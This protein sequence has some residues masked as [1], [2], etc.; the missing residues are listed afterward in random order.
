L[1]EEKLVIKIED[2]EAWA[3]FRCRVNSVPLESIVW[4]K[5]GVAIEVDLKAVE[6][7]KF[8]GLNNIDFVLCEFLEEE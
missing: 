5:R 1:K 4:T 3:D 8:T 6:E 7:F 2:V